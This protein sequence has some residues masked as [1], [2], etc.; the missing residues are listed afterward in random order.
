MPARARR[1]EAEQQRL[2]SVEEEFQDFSYIVSHDLAAS[3]R[4][5]TEFTRLLLDSYEH[6][7]TDQQQAHAER[8][9]VAGAR[10]QRMLEQ[11]LIFSRVQ[12]HPLECV[13][14]DAMPSVQLALL[15]LAT[16]IQTA[17]AEI[18][19]EP[20]GEVFADRKLLALAAGRLLDNAVKFRRPGVRPRIIVRAVEDAEFWRLQ[21]A[22]N[23]PGV[24]PAFREK[25]FRMFQKLNAD[26]DSAGVGA[27]LAISRRIARRHGGEVCF[28]DR[29]EG[30]CVEL[31]L[32]RRHAG[33]PTTT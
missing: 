26:D 30:A 12:Q 32:P 13:A 29:A 10:C 20:L 17:D 25:A 11:L 15:R 3:V 5:L 4:H 23:G 33:A 28:L 2:S 16:R 1:R 31:S 6:P 14:H 22:D 9:S 24:E 21:I 19:V 8:I 18:S 27:G 7:L